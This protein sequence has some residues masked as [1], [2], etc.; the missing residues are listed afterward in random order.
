MNLLI[1]LGISG[2]LFVMLVIGLFASKKI[3]KLDDFLV[4]GRSLPY[5]LATATLLAT[6]FGAG[7]CMG[8]S[9]AA[10]EEGFLGVIAD[11]FAAGVSLILAGFFYVHLL[12][13]LNLLTIT[14]VFGR[15]Y[16]KNA[17]IFASLLMVPVYI[18]WLGSQMVAMGYLINFLTD[19]P[20]LPAI[21]I[22]TA[23]LLIYTYAGGMWAVSLTDLFQVIVLAVGLI[24]LFPVVIGDLGGLSAIIDKTPKDFFALI[25]QTNDT[26]IWSA[27]FGQWALLGLGTVVGQD[28]VQRTLSSRSESV[29]RQSAWTAGVLYIALGC[30]PVFLGIGARLILP[31][32]EDPEMILPTL[33][34]TYLHPL[35]LILFVGALISAIMS[36]A[37]SA[38]LAASSLSV[39]NIL[40]PLLGETDDKKL[41]HWTRVATVVLSLL[42]MSVALYVEEI[43]SLMINSWATLFVAIFVPVTAALYWKKANSL[44][45]WTAMIS[46]TLAWIGL[47]AF[48]GGTLKNIDDVLFNQAAFYGGIVSLI[49][50][51]VVTFLQ[52]NLPEQKP[53]VSLPGSTH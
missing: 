20:T 28:L 8:A 15:Y 2:Y 51:L 6:W 30:I 24:F 17:E 31:E 9:G 32:I 50:Y 1:L 37:D 11:P 14:D 18:G 44:A 19:V 13:R 21:I 22:A 48:G 43:Y 16:G 3:Q 47:I 36:S 53:A 35:G 33:A 7:S 26:S 41:L 38:L 25:P 10:Y 4:A 42:A 23:V 52:K 45:A 12:R 29:A 27:Y 46:G 40:A 5:P 34:T 39:K 49:S